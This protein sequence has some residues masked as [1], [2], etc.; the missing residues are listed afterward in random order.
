[1]RATRSSRSVLWIAAA[2][3]WGCGDAVSDRAT[4]VGSDAGA[5]DA[6][7]AG[8][9][10]GKLHADAGEDAGAD[11]WVPPDVELPDADSDSAR[12]FMLSQTGLYRDIANKLLAPD[13]IAFEPTYKLW[14][15]GAE[16]HRYVRVPAGERIDTSDMDHWQFPVGTMFFKEFSLGG[17]RLET[18]LVARTGP[19][20][21]DYFMG[22]FV[23]NDDESD[24]TFVPDGQS[25]VRGTEHDVPKVK[26]CFTC[27]DGDTGR[28]LGFSAVQLPDAPVALLTE[29]PDAPFQ[30]PGD[31]RTVAALGY[32]HA[33]CAHCHNE[34]GAA[35]P[36]TDMILRLSVHDTRAEDTATYR[37]TVGVEMQYFESSPLSLRIAPGAA[38][39]SGVFF[40]MSQRGPKTQMP[41]LATE[42]VDDDGIESVRAWI[43]AL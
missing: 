18:R 30:V 34:N 2:L 1:M 20:E 40:R 22:A 25:N 43:D 12:T 8:R 11:A 5:L 16:K 15:D 4:H 10:G 28:V 14:S 24:A 32:L 13:L 7:S 33:N 29:P 31:A 39:D 36:D 3:A 17:K 38:E 27:H 35:R 9:D 6:S 41:P 37:T 21:R 19:G 23:W 26:N 42:I